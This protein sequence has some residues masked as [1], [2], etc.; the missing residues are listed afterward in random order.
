MI[1]FT[2]ASRRDELDK[3]KLFP[4]DGKTIYE[5]TE[6]NNQITKFLGN[7][8]KPFKIKRKDGITE[9]GTTICSH[10]K[11]DIKD[12]TYQSV[13]HE[14]YEMSENWWHKEREQK[15]EAEIWD[16]KTDRA[17]NWWGGGREIY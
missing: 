5:T 10:Y 6:D 11:T 4:Y 13:A 1:V 15:W 9:V 14:F 12:S 16:R 7:E 2:D 8:L 3:A 17:K